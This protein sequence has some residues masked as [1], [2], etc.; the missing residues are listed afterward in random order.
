M[1][2]AEEKTTYD[3][4]MAV[5]KLYQELQSLERKLLLL[6]KQRRAQIGMGFDTLI[7]REEAATMIG[8]CTRQLDRIAEKKGILKPYTTIYGLR[9]RMGDVV[10]Y[11][12]MRC[13]GSVLNE[14]KPF[15]IKT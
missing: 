9:Y 5:E 2:T 15:N 3:Y 1:T 8:I 14:P 10:A 7:T 4:F 13:E 11:V 12:Q 6:L